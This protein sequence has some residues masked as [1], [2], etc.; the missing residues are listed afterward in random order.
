MVVRRDSTANEDPPRSLKD[1]HQGMNDSR[2]I[3]AWNF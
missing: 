3:A 2:V 1:F